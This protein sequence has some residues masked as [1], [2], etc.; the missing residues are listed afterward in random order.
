MLLP[1]VFGCLQ[2]QSP[3]QSIPISW[4]RFSSLVFICDAKIGFI[5]RWTTCFCTVA[6]KQSDG[7][8]VWSQSGPFIIIL[9]FLVFGMIVGVSVTLQKRRSGYSL[10]PL[11]GKPRIKPVKYNAFSRVLMIVVYIGAALL[12]RSEAT[13]EPD[14]LTNPIISLAVEYTDYLDHRCIHARAQIVTDKAHFSWFEHCKTLNELIVQYRSPV[15]TCFPEAKYDTD[16][17]FLKRTNKSPIKNVAIFFM[18]SI[19]AEMIPF[20]YSSHFAKKLTQSALEEE[21][22][23]PF[24]SKL[25]KKARYTTRGRSLCSFTLK[26]MLGPLCSVYPF[27]QNFAPEYQYGFYRTCLPKLLKK[28]ADMSNIF[29]QPVPSK[30]YNHKQLLEHQGFEEIYDAERMARGDFGKPPSAYINPLGYED[31]PYR[32]LINGWIASQKRRGKNFFMTYESS[33]THAFFD[34][35]EDWEKKTFIKENDMLNKYVNAL[36]YFDNFLEGVMQNFRDHGFLENTLFVFLGDHGISLGEH[37]V[38][39]TTDIQ[40]ETQFEI[41]IILYTENKEWNE[42]FP[43]GKFDKPWSGLDILP[44]ILDALKFNGTDQNFTSNY[45]YEG[46]SLLREKYENRV[47]LSFTNPGMANIVIKE[48]NRKVVLP[49]M[50]WRKEEIYD[51]EKDELETKQL[52]YSQLPLEFRK[53]VEDMKSVRALYIKKIEEWYKQG[54]V[55]LLLLT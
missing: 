11:N 47:Q 2:I 39:Y 21:D 51:L 7:G 31:G 40:Y 44:T 54:S 38:W 50:G 25:V 37:N 17:T 19:R 18:E 26:A 3:F 45:L 30:F 8:F 15:Q 4:P 53:W 6:T 41:P 52:Y 42:R 9:I 16:Y 23:T 22:I 34:T 49:G 48:N 12:L 24:M 43:P 5:L 13:I 14:I 29:I 36:R 55:Q 35:P 33:I 10:L 20:N 27:P 46:Q 1:Y 32:K 28:H